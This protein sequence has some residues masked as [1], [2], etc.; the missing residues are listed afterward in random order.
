MIRPMLG[1]WIGLLALSG[2]PKDGGKPAALAAAELEAELAPVEPVNVRLNRAASLLTTLNRDDANQAIE[3]LQGVVAEDDSLAVAHFNL[4]VAYVQ[5]DGDA[6]AISAFQRVIELD[7]TYEDAW[8]YLGLAEERLGRSDA[9]MTTYRS[10]ISRF[11]RNIELRVALI[12]E[13]REQGFLDMAI[14]EAKTALKVNANS[15]A[16]Y[17]AMGRAYIEME[18]HDLA[19]FVYLKAEEL[20]GADESPMIQSQIGWVYYLRGEPRVAE[21]RLEKALEIRGNFVP[22]LV[23]LAWLRLQDRNYGD[24]VSLLELA[25]KED[26]TNHGV[27]MN[28]GIAYR[29]VGSFAQSQ[30][31]YE[32]ALE[33]HPD[34]PSPW[35]NLGILLGDYLKDYDGAVSAFKRYLGGGGPQDELAH[36]YIDKVQKEQ[37]RAKKRRQKDAERQAR[38]AERAER[39]RLL[40]EAERREAEEE[41]ERQRLLQEGAVNPV[42]AEGEGS[43][44]QAPAVQWGPVETE[45]AMPDSP[46][47]PGGELAADPTPDSDADPTAPNPEPAAPEQDPN[48]ADAPDSQLAPP[49]E[50]S[51]APVVEWGPTETDSEESPDPS[52]GEDA[53]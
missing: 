26:P 4:G 27:W 34:D 15:L 16:L 41:A 3:L 33:L 32:R 19:R 6:A 37:K 8:Y 17:D 9:A 5:V 1:L 30:Q 29:G 38:D 13:L 43:A 50:A 20:D 22:A 7:D 21:A 53:P 49:E 12:A 24:M 42:E 18:E 40:E 23:Y 10:A 25:A 11:P 2:C 35:F 39:Q 44:G 36:E 14:D 47:A 46:P 45:P 52:V 28:L 31:A 48:T 51:D